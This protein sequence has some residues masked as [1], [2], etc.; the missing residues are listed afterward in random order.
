MRNN[1]VLQII[2]VT[3]GIVLS[4]VLVIL[5]K[6]ISIEN[7]KIIFDY[8]WTEIQKPTFWLLTT[9]V[10][11]C[12]TF[13]Y[14]G[15]YSLSRDKLIHSDEFQKTVDIYNDKLKLKADNF[16]EYIRLNNL[17]EK[18]R[19][20]KEKYKTKLHHYEYKLAT[21]PNSKLQSR[22]AIRYKNK[23]SILSN[24]LEEEFIKNN[25]IGAR[26]K[27]TEIYA[28]N[29][30]YGN[31][32][33]IEDSRKDHSFE[34]TKMT[35]ITIRKVFTNLIFSAAITIF[36]INAIF[37]FKF[38]ANF[39]SLMIST[40]FSMMLN[41][42]FAIKQADKIYRSDLLLPLIN[43]TDILEKYAQWNLSGENKQTYQ[44]I[45]DEYLK[46]KLDIER[47]SMKQ[48]YNEKIQILENK[49]NEI[50]QTSN[51]I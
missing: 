33:I 24:M 27:Y 3:L 11:I 9:S 28:T 38:N 41:C 20:Y 15:F 46:S 10:T 6:S 7:D 36:I 17:E 34:G 18:T 22:K 31:Y 14:L 29:F 37:E 51:S 49:F 25:I 50:K 48:E 1:R 43:K 47:K 26:V 23:I 21:I 16:D 2:V 13:A 4:F 8:D 39:W 42:Y 45:L 44:N 35:A 30:R 32:G 40:L 12:T 5:T 19:R